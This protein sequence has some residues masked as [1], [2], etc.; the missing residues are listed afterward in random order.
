MTHLF[1]IDGD[2]LTLPASPSSGYAHEPSVF[3]TGNGFIG[4]RGVREEEGALQ[5]TRPRDVV[6]LNGVFE[7]QPIRYHE[8]AYGFPQQSEVRI[9]VLDCTAMHFRIDGEA[10]PNAVWAQS[11]EERWLDLATGVLSRRMAFTNQNGGNVTVETERFV[12]I[13]RPN[14]VAMRCRV[15][16]VGHSGSFTVVNAVHSPF[17]QRP[18]GEAYAKDI[19]DP[20]IGPGLSD[21][22]WQM[23]REEAGD[24]TCRFLYRT[25]SSRVGVATIHGLRSENGRIS[26]F[27]SVSGLPAYMYE[28][29]LDPDDP[30]S[31]EART[32]YATDRGD[33]SEDIGSLAEAAFQDAMAADHDELASS[34]ETAMRLFTAEAAIRISGDPDLTG[35]LRFNLLQ[36]FMATGRDGRSSIGAKGQTGEGYEGHVFWD[37]EIFVLPHFTFS[38]PDIARSMLMYR[39][40]ML[41][42]ARAIARTMG[43]RTGALYPWRT[44]TGPECSSYFPAGSAQY[45]INADI[46]YAV[47]QYVEASGDL[48]FL[49]SHGLEMLVETA[50]LWPQAG[51]F[52][53]RKGGAFCINRVTGPDEYSALVD[54]NLYTNIMARNHLAYTLR[55]LDDLRA[56]QPGIYNEIKKAFSLTDAETD[57]WR[58]IAAR[59]FLPHDAASGLYLQAE[60][61]LDR[62]PWDFARTTAEHYPLLLHHHPLTIYRH[63]V[64]KQADAVMAMV[65]CPD[66]FSLPEKQAA[67]AFYDAITTHDSTLSA[68]SFGVLAARC[69]AHDRAREFLETTAYTDLDDLYGNSSHGLHMAALANSWNALVFGFAGLQASGGELRFSPE[70]DEQLG[71]YAFSIRFRSRQIHVSVTRE[72]VRYDLASG[73]PISLTHHGSVCRLEDTLLIPSASRPDCP[74]SKAAR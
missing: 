46:A 10:V 28:G 63:Q 49:H 25:K 33:I 68:G 1:S 51:F 14:L 59:M 66:S 40:S 35:A 54:N 17:R 60:H 38:Q 71:D 5:R 24:D 20:R 15:E 44:I 21:N 64:C 34:H 8:G 52:N 56:E 39:Y 65:L 12:S 11:A 2:R 30:L 29:P 13:D 62:E 73:D 45:H 37:A 36:A 58:E 50:R 53:P 41:D 26:Q 70:H 19:Y 42:S 6:Y 61:I 47:Q 3:S 27:P 69:G 9:P 7:H 16:S 31:F 55:C 48:E 23:I 67:L 43:H 4:V 18:P 32:V 74:P 57:G 72:S 22:P